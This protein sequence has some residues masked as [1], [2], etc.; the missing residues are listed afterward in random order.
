MRSLG[1]QTSAY[2]CPMIVTS[3]KSYTKTFDGASIMALINPFGQKKPRCLIC[4]YTRTSMPR[5]MALKAFYHE[6][7][8]AC[9]MQYIA[10]E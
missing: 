6:I 10:V 7:H 3:L 2:H 1:T 4:R 5:R 8:A 9:Q